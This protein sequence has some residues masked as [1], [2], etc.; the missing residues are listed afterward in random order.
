[1]ICELIEAKAMSKERVPSNLSHVSWQV[2][3]HSVIEKH[4][5]DGEEDMAE[6]ILLV[7][8]D[9]VMLKL[10]GRLIQEHTPYGLV[11]T[12][13]PLEGLELATHNDFDLV[14]TNMKMPYIDGTELLDA[15][16][17]VR[18]DVPVI[19][20]SSYSSLEASMEAMHKGASDYIIQPVKREQMLVAIEKALK[21]KRLQRENKRLTERMHKAERSCVCGS[22]VS[23]ALCA[24]E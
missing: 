10:T 2:D 21:W 14:I 16:K 11:A 5:N 7:D 20:M 24:A 1:M 4:S 15:V 19:V 8:D 6:K 22:M 12:N 23:G 9:T 3:G 18:A 17:R 13:N